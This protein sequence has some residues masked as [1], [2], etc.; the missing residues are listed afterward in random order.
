MFPEPQIEAQQSGFDLEKEEPRS[1]VEERA[2]AYTSVISEPCAVSS[3]VVRPAGLEPAT[4]GLK[5][6]CS[7]T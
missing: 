6:R 7:T 4:Y 5:D 2:G 1:T 3:D